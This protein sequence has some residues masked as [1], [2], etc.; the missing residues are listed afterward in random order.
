VSLRGAKPSTVETKTSLKEVGEADENAT[1]RP[2]LVNEKPNAI[3]ASGPLTRSI[4]LP[5][6][7]RRK[8]CAAVFCEP[9]K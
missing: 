6:G 2:S 7:S 1:C 8:R 3:S 4:D 5:A 9:E